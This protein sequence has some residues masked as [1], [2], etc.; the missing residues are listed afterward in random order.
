MS[1]LVELLRFAKMM[2][3]L[4]ALSVVNQPDVIQMLDEGGNPHSDLVCKLA[5]CLR[6]IA[7]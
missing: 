3:K 4:F 2:L 7:G 1:I 6:V 5:K